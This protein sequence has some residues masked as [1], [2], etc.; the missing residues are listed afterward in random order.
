MS[1]EHYKNKLLTLLQKPE[2]VHGIP[3]YELQQVVEDNQETTDPP[4]RDIPLALNKETG[5]EATLGAFSTNITEAII[6]LSHERKIHLRIPAKMSGTELF[7]LYHTANWGDKTALFFKH[8]VW[9]SNPKEFKK[10]NKKGKLPL[11][12]SFVNFGQQP[13]VKNMNTSF[14]LEKVGETNDG[15]SIIRTNWYN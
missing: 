6:Q 1:V 12:V 11:V 9:C 7:T 3:T 5:M 10:Y 2:N 14:W 15:K 8:W 13:T 4:Y